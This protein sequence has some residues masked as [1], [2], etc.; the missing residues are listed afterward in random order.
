MKKLVTFIILL[1]I[2]VSCQNQSAK[3]S[4]L[5]E[6]DPEQENEK[7][8][9]IENLENENRPYITYSEF[10]LR[11][12][13]DSIGQLNPDLLAKGMTKKVDS[14]LNNQTTLNHELSTADF[15]KLKTASKEQLID[16]DFA[17]KIFP[18]FQF[19]S[20]LRKF[21]QDKKIPIEFYSFDKNEYDFNEFV[22][23]IRTDFGKGDVYFF[24]NKKIIAK[25]AVYYRYHLDLK[26]FKDENNQTVIYYKLFY[27]SGSGICW[28]QFNFYKYQND[29]ITPLLTEIHDI[30]YQWLYPRMVS[31]K[32]T[33]V[34]ERPL[35]LQF[36]YEN[37]FCD[38]TSDENVVFDCPR[39]EFIKDSTI[40]TYNI[41]TQSGI[42]VPNFT[43]TKLDRNKLLSYFLINESHFLFVNT[44]YNL[45]SDGLNSKDD[46][47]RNAILI[48]L[49]QL[50]NYR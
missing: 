4:V 25:H 1:I 45:F 22:I 5:T 46:K 7:V 18:N 10:E 6:N 9:K 32:S 15:E 23:S 50:K 30:T 3:K 20:D 29:K 36:V 11:L 27:E 39:I 16:I 33:I 49:N 26:H 2:L 8:D 40:V 19:D 34:N 14:V 12:F 41:D 35:Q 21:R 31:I 47:L 48:Y 42:Y 28:I 37:H 43:G 24:R 13:L 17:K 44:H 38:P